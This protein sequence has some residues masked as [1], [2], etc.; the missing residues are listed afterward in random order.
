[1]SKDLNCSPVAVVS[2]I[3]M[4]ASSAGGDALAN[5][6]PTDSGAEQPELTV[7]V[8]AIAERIRNDHPTGVLGLTPGSKIAQWRN[9]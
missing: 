1:M 9:Y 2:L 6:S 5:T 4:I 7:R 8:E 3:A